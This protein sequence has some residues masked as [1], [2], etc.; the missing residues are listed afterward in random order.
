VSPV[1]GERARAGGGVRD[2]DYVQIS[3]LP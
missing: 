3:S 2:E 1:E